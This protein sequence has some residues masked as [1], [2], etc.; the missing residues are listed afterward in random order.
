MGGV[1]KVWM[2]LVAGVVVLIEVWVMLIVAVEVWV[3][4]HIVCSIVEVIEVISVCI[5]SKMG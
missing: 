5:F 1:V 2:I 3:V 4:V